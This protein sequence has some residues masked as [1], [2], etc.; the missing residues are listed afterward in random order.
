MPLEVH[1]NL[2][3]KYILNV[4]SSSMVASMRAKMWGFSSEATACKTWQHSVKSSA[5]K[6]IGTAGVRFRATKTNKKSS[7]LAEF[8]KVFHETKQVK[9]TRSEMKGPCPSNQNR[10][11]FVICWL[12]RTIRLKPDFTSLLFFSSLFCFLPLP[13]LFLQSQ[14]TIRLRMVTSA[15]TKFHE[16]INV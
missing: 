10:F 5:T 7:S 14:L 2:A 13:L 15:Q 11:A 3:N 12:M 6:Q 1:A 8:E 4:S 9:T 16:R